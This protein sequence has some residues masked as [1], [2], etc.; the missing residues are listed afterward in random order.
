ME[1][2]AGVA[3]FHGGDELPEVESGG[4]LREASFSG[5]FV[6]EF[7]SGGELHDEVDFGF[8]GED[9]EEVDD[10]AVVE[11]PHD[12]DLA[13]HVCGETAVEDFALANGFHRHALARVHARRVIHLRE[14]ANAE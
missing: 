4:I 9:F 1:H 12:R 5:D 13:L 8:G 6:E 14:C 7:A 3:V 11:A 10:V 2:A